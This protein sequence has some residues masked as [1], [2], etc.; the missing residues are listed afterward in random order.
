[1]GKKK[2][3]LSYDWILKTAGLGQRDT[4]SPVLTAM[5]T[6]DYQHLHPTHI[7]L[8][9]FVNDFTFWQNP[10]QYK[11]E[12]DSYSFQP[13]VYN[14]TPFN[15]LHCHNIMRLAIPKNQRFRYTQQILGIP[16]KQH[17]VT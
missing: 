9:S 8:A 2:K 15:Q 10:E 5:F 4:L 7:N 1:M 12:L 11:Y 16:K 17:N 13:F 14:R 3:K 6:N